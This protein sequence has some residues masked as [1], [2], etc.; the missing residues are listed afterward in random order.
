MAIVFSKNSGLNDDLWKTI[1][2][3]LIA[4]MQDTD[5]EKNND[6]AIV[7]QLFN[8]KKSKK[9]GERQT[10]MTEFGN[11]EV[12]N[13]G[14]VAVLDELEETYPKTIVH[15][16]FMKKFV[17]TA[18]M[19]EDMALDEMKLAS[20]NFIR[21]YK[22]SRAQF[23]TD[24][25]CGE[26]ATF[27][28]GG[29]SFDRTSPDG[30]A[31]F[32]QGHTGKHMSGTQSN[33][34]TNALMADFTSP[35][36]VML[37]KLANIGRNFKN[38]SGNVMGYTFD[39]IVIPG[40]CPEMEDALTRIIR[41]DLIVGSPNNDINTQKGK[42]KLVVNHRWEATSGN[43]YI[44]M[45]SDANKELNGS[46]FFDRIPL[47]VKNDVDLDTQ[48]LEWVGR[49]RMSAG[50]YNWRPFILGGATAGTTLS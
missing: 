3:A 39:T 21:A 7:T 5:N 13:E 20:Q 45:S 22:R 29:K 43:P 42:W 27:T 15:S 37:N 24:A 28:Y 30:Q 35:D 1:D 49:A 25:L 47:T 17:C 6:D 12:V 19:A 10:G 31:L 38:D 41:S 23:A 16:Q 26:G 33:V 18:E 9:F 14:N 36:T 2:T 34:Y 50:F 32:A 11:F 4:V 8:T 46:V 40:N 48:N 44:L